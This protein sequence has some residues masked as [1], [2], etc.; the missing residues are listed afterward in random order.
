MTAFEL[1]LQHCI[2]ASFKQREIHF[3]DLIYFKSEHSAK[4]LR[5]TIFRCSD[6][7]EMLF[8]LLG[9]LI[10]DDVSGTALILPL[11]LPVILTLYVAVRLSKRSDTRAFPPGPKCIPFI[12]PII[13]RAFYYS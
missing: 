8:E 2:K 3:Y 13:S 11:A 6:L 1:C 10:G 7:L 4:V 5:T 12:G 9:G